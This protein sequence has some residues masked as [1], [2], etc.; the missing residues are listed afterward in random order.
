[1]NLSDIKYF[2][3]NHYVSSVLEICNS[4]TK[5]KHH[6]PSSWNLAKH[7]E[8]PSLLLNCKVKSHRFWGY[9]NLY[10][11]AAVKV[12]PKWNSE[13]MKKASRSKQVLLIVADDAICWLDVGAKIGSSPWHLHRNKR[14][15]KSKQSNWKNEMSYKS[16]VLNAFKQAANKNIYGDSSL[17]KTRRC[18]PKWSPR[19][20]QM[21]LLL[22]MER[23]HSI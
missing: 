22:K 13:I 12:L 6:Q 3:T 21:V 23:S 15:A 19:P 20:R 10:A 8:S 2:V 4:T 11:G 5:D 16:R 14:N 17:L 7:C 18:L 9:A 1:M